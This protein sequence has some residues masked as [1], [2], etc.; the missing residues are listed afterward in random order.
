[1]KKK[2]LFFVIGL[3]LINS[4]CFAQDMT[5]DSYGN[6]G[7][8]EVNPTA[9]LD[10]FTTVGDAI[11]GESSSGYAGYFLG[12][13]RITG[14]LTVDGTITSSLSSSDADTLDGLDSTDFSLLIHSHDTTYVNEGQA[15]SITSAMIT[16]G[17][18]QQ[19]D[20]SFTPGDSHSLDAADGSPTDVVYVDNNGN[21]GIGTTIPAG[22]LDIN[23]DIC[24][25]SVCRT[26]WPAGS[27]TGAFTDTGSLAY[28]TGG[29]VGI[30][31]T[32]PET[33]EGIDTKGIHLMQPVA[34][35]DNATAGVRLEIEGIVEGGI[36]S[37]YNQVS[38]DG[39]VF[40]GTLTNHRLGFVTNSIEKMSLTPDGSLGIGTKS[41]LKLLH[42]QGDAYV[43]NNLGI[44]VATP[45][46][47][48]QLSGSNAL[49]SSETGDFRFSLSK[50]KDTDNASIIFQNNFGGRAEVGLTQD[51]NFHIKVSED[52]TVFTDAVIIDHI[53]GNVGIGSSDTEYKLHVL[54]E[55]QTAILAESTSLTPAAKII[56]RGEG[57]GLRVA[58]PNVESLGTAFDIYHMGLG[59]AMTVRSYTENYM[60]IDVNGNVGI[61]TDTPQSSLQ[62]NGYVQLGLTSTAPPSADCD[63]ATERGRMMVE[64][65][66]EILYICMDSGW[67]AK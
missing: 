54:S 25:G 44:G 21:V 65:S 63:E 16:D 35:L 53:H 36:A 8:G 46:N 40:V 17:T 7:I 39:G 38:G 6:V 66:S 60:I 4:T 3:L 34:L 28:Y 15:N 27:G 2:L 62:V 67:V 49:F 30:G 29:N 14:N 26:T 45:T 59:P 33:L 22:K 41:P 55:T 56:Q 18:I 31:T 13:T 58:K 9:K 50:K 43:S 51:D 48:L 1:M 61:G 64:S 20:L 5:I 37:A 11:V 24:L 19:S 52:G 47:N 57:A 42:V 32:S 12:N 10:V 23:G